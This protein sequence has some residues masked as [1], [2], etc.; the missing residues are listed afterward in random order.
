MIQEKVMPKIFDLEKF[1]EKLPL[2]LWDINQMI[3]NSNFNTQERA[4][5]YIDE[6]LCCQKYN[7]TLESM[8]KIIKFIQEDIV[9]LSKLVSYYEHLDWD[10]SILLNQNCLQWFLFLKFT[11]VNYQLYYI[12]LEL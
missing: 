2:G 11:T 4:K 12:N 3:A 1:V 6:F 10:L 7:L 5:K 8:K 9:S